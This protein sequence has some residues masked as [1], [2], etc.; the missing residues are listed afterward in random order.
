MADDAYTFIHSLGVDKVDIFAFSLGCIPGSELIMH[1]DSG[2]GGIF[3]N[4]D[5][6]APVKEYSV[7]TRWRERRDDQLP[8]DIQARHLRRRV[9]PY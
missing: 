3:Q 2:H 1:A 6:F 8:S 7:P 5:K 4:H 9:P